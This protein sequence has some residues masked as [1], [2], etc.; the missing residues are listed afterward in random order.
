MCAGVD[1][2][3]PF[4]N[5]VQIELAGVRFSAFLGSDPTTT[6]RATLYIEPS[7]LSDVNGI[8]QMI[9]RSNGAINSVD[10]EVKLFRLA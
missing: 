1:T 7:D 2:S 3:I 4:Q 5:F 9:V 8:M 6:L 10:G